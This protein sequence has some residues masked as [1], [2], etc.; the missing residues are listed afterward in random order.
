[1]V[2]QLIPTVFLAIESNSANNKISISRRQALATRLH[3]Y[4]HN[5]HAGPCRVEKA[6]GGSE[7]SVCV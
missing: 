5:T 7:W 4:L 2:F 1:M 6:G 3:E